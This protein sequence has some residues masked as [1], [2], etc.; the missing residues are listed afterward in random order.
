M[1]IFCIAISELYKYIKTLAIP[2]F[3]NLINRT[4]N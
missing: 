1:I 2:N 4:H 3:D